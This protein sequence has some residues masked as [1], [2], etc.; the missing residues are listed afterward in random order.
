MPKFS[1]IIPTFNREKFVTLALDSVLSQS[2]SD[3]EIIVID[4]G[5]TDNTRTALDPYRK[6]IRYIYQK[7]SG[8]SGARNAGIRE[9]KGEWIAFL[10]SDDEWAPNYLATQMEHAREFPCA[11]AHL[12]NAVTLFP[13]GR[14]SEHF[15]EIQ[16]L[17]RLGRQSCVMF[18]KPFSLIL[19]HSHWF[20]Q[21]SIMLR[22]VLLQTGLFDPL[23]SI[24]EDLDVIARM[25]LRGPFTLSRTVLVRI[26]RRDEPIEH[27]ASQRVKKGLY[28]RE[29][30]GKV[31]SNLLDRGGLSFRQK[32]SAARALSSNRRALGNIL[33]RT[34]K[35]SEARHYY[36][37]ALFLYPSVRSLIKY[38]A[39]FLPGKISAR[40]IREGKDILPGENRNRG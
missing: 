27:L 5:S 9:A 4:D 30:F 16:L 6:R 33:L 37:K 25:A 23:L 38:L 24:A 2:F 17:K 13:G 8:V 19:D 11:I 12:T 32:L 29:A 22:D 15:E 10:D 21:S 20:L 39:A 18:E 3:Y 14:R 28:S 36:R 34:G 31:Y 1:V 40:L 26:W 35:R 7:N